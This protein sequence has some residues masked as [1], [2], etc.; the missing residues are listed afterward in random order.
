[1]HSPPRCISQALHHR[2]ETHLGMLLPDVRCPEGLVVSLVAGLA[3]KGLLVCS[4]VWHHIHT[5]VQFKVDVSDVYT[6]L[7]EDTRLASLHGQMSA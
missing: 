5:K 6:A 1:M 3:Q 2:L 7:K 4:P